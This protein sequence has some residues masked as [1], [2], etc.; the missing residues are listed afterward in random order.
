MQID[1]SNIQI[2]K[3]GIA[4]AGLLKTDRMVY[5]TGLQGEQSDGE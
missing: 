5:L 2:R 4:E 1:L 3:I